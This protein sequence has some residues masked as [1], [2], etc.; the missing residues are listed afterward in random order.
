MKYSQDFI[1]LGRGTHL[2]GFPAL[3]GKELIHAIM[4]AWTLA[5][6]SESLCAVLQ[7]HSYSLS[8][9][10]HLLKNPI[11]FFLATRTVEGGHLNEAELFKVFLGKFGSH[12]GRFDHY[13]GED[14]C[15]DLLCWDSSHLTLCYFDWIIRPCKTR[16]DC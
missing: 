5:A 8:Y 2:F 11:F 1:K 4:S 16:V 15:S 14:A 7:P 3:I 13:R 6:P 9:S 10:D 12:R